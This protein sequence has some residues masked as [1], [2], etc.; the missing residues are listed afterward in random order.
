MS[1]A[2]GAPLRR[3]LVDL[4]LFQAAWL[5]CV[6]MAA[7]GDPALGMAAVAAALLRHALLSRARGQDAALLAACLAVGAVWDTLLARSGLVIYASPWP[8]PGV[9]PAWILA[10]WALLASALREPLR[11]LHARPLVAALAG[12]VGGPL[13]YWSAIRLG[14]GHA[15]AP[16]AATLALACGWAVMTPALTTLAGWLARRGTAAEAA[17][18]PVPPHLLR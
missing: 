2:F 7:R 18:P 4:L 8:G 14:A 11:A 3:L 1:L 9:A 15:G 16:V 10:L 12:A 13:S 5:A 17:G 6:C